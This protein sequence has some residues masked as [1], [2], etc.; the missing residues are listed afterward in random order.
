MNSSIQDTSSFAS[1]SAHGAE[2]I[3][4]L[5]QENSLKSQEA[6]KAAHEMQM[7]MDETMVRLNSLIGK[8]KEIS[9]VSK[10]VESIALETKLL[11]FNASIEA[12]RAGEHGHGFRAVANHIQELAH[13]TSRQTHEIF[14]LIKTI[15]A[16]LEPSQRAIQ[17]NHTLAQLTS[18]KTQEVEKTF[19]EISGLISKAAENIGRIAGS[20]NQQKEAV[21]VI[22]EKLKSTDEATQLV[23]EE[24]AKILENTSSLN[25]MVEEAYVSFGKIDTQTEFHRLLQMGR[26]LVL[27]TEAVFAKK[28]KEKNLALA[29]I[30]SL[31]Y[32]EIRGPMIRSLSRLFDVSKVPETGFE[33]KKYSTEYDFHVDEELQKIYDSAKAQEKNLVF[34]ILLDL[35]AYAPIHNTEFC[36][37]WTGQH[38]KDLAGNR[39]KRFF[40]DNNVLVRGA[41]VG[42]SQDAMALPHKASRHDLE[43]LDPVGMKNSTD[44]QYL[45]QT[46]SRD[47][48]AVMTVLTIPVYIDSQR[49][50]AIALGWNPDTAS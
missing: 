1:E 4:I 46:Y 40:A 48:G 33:P 3:K 24:T 50:G 23:L 45:V 28:M 14:N 36:K 39:V 15:N 49:F 31:T 27:E 10:V 19:V 17:D 37:A 34:A 32:T 11:A 21:E 42:L 26:D 38:E 41:R 2:Q 18:Q 13:S 29:E 12:A 43:R 9:S 44:G 22:A 30:L 5:V 7:K 35:N 8:I 25:S 47:T 6:H 20:G 16:E